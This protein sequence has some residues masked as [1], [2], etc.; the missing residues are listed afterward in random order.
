MSRVVGL[1]CPNRLV[2]VVVVVVEMYLVSVSLSFFLFFFANRVYPNLAARISTIN[3]DK[4]AS[5]AQV[6]V[7]GVSVLYEPYSYRMGQDGTAGWI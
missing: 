1:N 5:A 3:S 4:N 7:R 2:V 6:C